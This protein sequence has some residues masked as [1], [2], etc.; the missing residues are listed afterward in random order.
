MWWYCWFDS[1]SSSTAEEDD[2]GFNRKGCDAGDSYG[3]SPLL[4]GSSLLPIIIL[5]PNP[6]QHNTT[7]RVRVS[8]LNQLKW[9]L[10]LSTHQTYTTVDF[11]VFS[12]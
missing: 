2:E 4:F 5:Q 12:I 9:C 10:K 8:G 1:D 3:K 6:T 7:Q 11:C